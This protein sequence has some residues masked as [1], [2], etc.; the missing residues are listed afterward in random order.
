MLRL[1]I[2]KEIFY[3]HLMAYVSFY[4]NFLLNLKFK[5]FLFSIKMARLAFNIMLYFNF[6]T[7]FIHF[8][9]SK[10]INMLPPILLVYINNDLKRNCFSL[11]V[12]MLIVKF[13]IYS[14]TISK[15][16]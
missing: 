7:L 9:N 10:L 1:I 12:L 15:S 13:N 6:S 16:I 4:L 2:I 8:L 5:P 3:F 14:S 11:L